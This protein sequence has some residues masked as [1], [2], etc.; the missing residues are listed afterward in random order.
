MAKQANLNQARLSDDIEH[1]IYVSI[2]FIIKIVAFKAK[3][4]SATYQSDNV[5]NASQNLNTG[6]YY[7]H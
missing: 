7:N 1:F 5:T 6:L 2:Q 3:Y 4:S